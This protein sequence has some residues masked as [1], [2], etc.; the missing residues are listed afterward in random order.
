M[1]GKD[2]LHCRAADEPTE[3][4]ERAHDSCVAP[5]RV[6]GRDANGELAD[7]VV[8]AWPTGSA[9]GA[10]IVLPCDELSMLTKDRV[11]RDD[12]RQRAE[13]LSRKSSAFSGE[14]PS[15]GVGEAKSALAEELSKDAVLFA[16]VV[17]GVQL[18]S[19]H[20][21]GDGED[22]EVKGGRRHEGD[23]TSAGPPPP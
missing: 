12:G 13:L 2:P 20:P 14:A 3:V 16:E 5:A 15:L 17:D 7:L 21:S 8:D 1:F 6:L 19:V 9:V 10:A 11:R 4:V 23:L 18:P 22:E